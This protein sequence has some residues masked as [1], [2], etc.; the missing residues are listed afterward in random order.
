MSETRVTRTVLASA[1][2]CV[3]MTAA[4]GGGG[5]ASPSAPSRPASASSSLASAMA[6]GQSTPSSIFGSS[7][8]D[9][10]VCLH[11]SA[12][13]A[14]FSGARRS[15]QTVGAAAT[16]PGAPGGFSSTASGST[17]TLTWTA[18]SSG[19]PVTTYVIEA[20]STSGAAN[21]ANVVTNST[22]TTFSA[23]GVGSGTYYV[24]VR[25]QNAAGVSDPSNESILTVG[26]SA[27]TS[28]PGS[29]SGLAGA[30]SGGTVTLTWTAPSGGCAATSYVLQ[31][32]SAAGLSDLANSS[33]GSTATAF[34]ASGVGAGTYY[35]RVRAANAYGQ[36][37]G[38]NEVAL[39]VGGTPPPTP[40]TGRWVGV[41]RDGMII[42]LDPL[43]NCPA[44]YDLQLD[45]TSTGTAVTGT[46]TTRLRRVEAAGDCSNVLGQVATWSVTNL[47]VSSG[48]ISFA[49]GNTGVFRFSGTFTAT[50]MTGSFVVQES[51]PFYQAGSFALNRQ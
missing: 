50:R 18:P 34:S 8:V 28:A 23:S 5:A 51:T 41:S 6:I 40:V 14:C 33:T 27:C 37:A 1:L 20:G 38:S 3:L 29:P 19:D 15:A 12:D 45:L 47:S 36:S 7:A 24:R 21:L 49:L 31:A 25:A 30:A 10:A 16:A 32:G 4:C 17:V 39:V 35:V 13:A 42:E 11:A 46:A 43:D 44:E 48:T 22:A 2:T 9:L 26:T